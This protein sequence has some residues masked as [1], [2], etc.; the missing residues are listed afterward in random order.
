MNNKNLILIGL[1]LAVL[2]PIVRYLDRDTKA[3]EI[4][5]ERKQENEKREKDRIKEEQEQAIQD[6]KDK[7]KRE[8]EE[9]LKSCTDNF[10]NVFRGCGGIGQEA[11]K[12]GVVTYWDDDGRLEYHVSNLKIV[13]RD[14]VSVLIGKINGKEHNL[15]IDVND[16]FRK[17]FLNYQNAVSEN[18]VGTE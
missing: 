14:G 3:E 6:A 16:L 8:K 13:Q 4:A 18:T 15:C 7:A 2:F 5:A 10:Q 11:Y 12:N 9:Y 17:A 1:C